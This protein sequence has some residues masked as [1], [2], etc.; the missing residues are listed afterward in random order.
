MGVNRGAQHGA[1]GMGYAAVRYGPDTA[2]LGTHYIYYVVIIVLVRLFMTHGYVAVAQNIALPLTYTSKDASPVKR[3]AAQLV[4]L[5][6]K[7]R[8]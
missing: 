8:M 1:D 4:A 3:F 6:S 7:V 2:R 5:G